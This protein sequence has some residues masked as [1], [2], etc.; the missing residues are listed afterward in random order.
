ML[1]RTSP[2]QHY[3]FILFWINNNHSGVDFTLAADLF[4]HNEIDF[5]K[6]LVAIFGDLHI[7]FR[8]I[9]CKKCSNLVYF[10]LYFCGYENQPCSPLHE[11]IYFAKA[12]LHFIKLPVKNI[13]GN[14]EHASKWKNLH[15]RMFSFSCTDPLRFR[16]RTQKFINLW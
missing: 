2:M 4:I 16:L 5:T 6:I 8:R 12:Q 1:H 13:D 14:I 9:I 15:F 10:S 3:M 11:F 7:G